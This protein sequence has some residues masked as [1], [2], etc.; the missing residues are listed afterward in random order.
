[1][2]LITA[3]GLIFIPTATVYAKKHT[4]HS[5]RKIQNCLS[6]LFP[7]TPPANTSANTTNPLANIDKP[8]SGLFSNRT[9][10]TNQTGNPLI[11]K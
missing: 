2:I 3:I 11:L 10:T 5:L 4:C 9:A 7:S 6:S 8:L 1:M